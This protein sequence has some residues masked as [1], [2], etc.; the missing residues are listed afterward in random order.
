MAAVKGRASY[1]KK[2]GIV[3]VS[4]DRTVVSWTPTVTGTPALS[5]PIDTITSKAS[6]Y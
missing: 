6:L 5:I 2:D 4:D 3:A 1:K